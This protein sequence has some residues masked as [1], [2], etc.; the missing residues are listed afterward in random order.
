MFLHCVGS[1]NTVKDRIIIKK[2]KMI[3]NRADLKTKWEAGGSE[4]GDKCKREDTDGNKWENLRGK[5]D[6][7]G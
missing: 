2:E 1:E 7:M 3:A 6:I 5:E 4:E